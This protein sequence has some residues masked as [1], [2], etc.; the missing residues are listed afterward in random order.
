MLIVGIVCASLQLGMGPLDAKHVE[1]LPPEVVEAERTTA[2]LRDSL[3]LSWMAR[4]AA[5]RFRKSATPK[6]REQLKTLA[7]LYKAQAEAA[8]KDGKVSVRPA[9]LQRVLGPTLRA[10]GSRDANGVDAAAF[11][12]A[13]SMVQAEVD[14]AVVAL[15]LHQDR[16]NALREDMNRLRAELEDWPADE[17]REVT[18]HDAEGRSHTASLTREEAEALLDELSTVYETMGDMSQLMTLNLQS[19]LQQSQQLFSMLSQMAKMMHD[20][21]K[22][23]INN[24]RD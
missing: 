8:A 16:R 11:E 19:A 21:T 6:Q 1:P 2:K 9:D 17:K 7:T 10:L 18:W 3:E 15:K 5:A 22:S 13:V 12:L 14:D 20:T 23:I 4:R 24:M